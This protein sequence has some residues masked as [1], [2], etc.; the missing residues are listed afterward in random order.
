MTVPIVNVQVLS[1]PEWKGRR[2]PET[3]WEL[4]WQAASQLPY[5]K[6]DICHRMEFPEGVYAE[7]AQRA[8]LKRA[9]REGCDQQG[10]RFVTQARRNLLL[11]RRVS[12][13]GPGEEGWSVDNTKVLQ[14]DGGTGTDS[15]PE[16]DPG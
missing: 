10:W 2:R 5:G 9:K 7:D 16:R 8:L 12:I 6:P 3:K 11:V 1:L 15:D 14:G 4:V 13:I